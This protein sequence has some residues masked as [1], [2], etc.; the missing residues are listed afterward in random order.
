MKTKKL[1]I[2][3]AIVILPLSYFFW[4]STSF[5]SGDKVILNSIKEV[6][7]A[8]SFEYDSNVSLDF[9]YD[10]RN[11]VGEKTG[12]IETANI[13]AHISGSVDLK[14]KE[15]INGTM[16][17]LGEAVS[18]G[19][20]FN[21]MWAEFEIRKIAD[22]LY[23]MIS[24]SPSVPPYNIKSME[25][26]WIKIEKEDSE[27]RISQAKMEN[28]YEGFKN[29]LEK[30]DFL[31]IKDEKLEEIGGEETNHY[32]FSINKEEIKKAAKEAYVENKSPESSN[33]I[34]TVE[35]F[36]DSA[37]FDKAEAWIGADGKLKK[38]LLEVSFSKDNLFEAEGNFK[39]EAVL[40]N[41][42]E[43]VLVEIP[44]SSTPFQKAFWESVGNKSGAA[45]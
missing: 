6:E 1:L 23:L 20:A 31:E 18:S 35:N 34:L 22:V 9:S 19:S 17:F 8:K 16:R 38:I 25:G 24:R 13:K 41:F 4:N 3:L 7:K 28:L 32:G 21:K 43:P 33:R 45:E 30:G 14:N 37:S 12:K 36:L 44:D 26:K 5:V 29:S 2:I 39:L 27:N 10:S 11:A 15:K 40:D 42:D